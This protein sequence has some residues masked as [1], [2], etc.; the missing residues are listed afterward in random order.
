MDKLLEKFSEEKM[1][2]LRDTLVQLE[3]ALSEIVE[4]NI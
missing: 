2:D 1:I 3:Q 4:F